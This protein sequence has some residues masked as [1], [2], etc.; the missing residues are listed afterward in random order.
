[1]PAT[2][3]QRPSRSGCRSTIRICPDLRA[4]CWTGETPVAAQIRTISTGGLS[5]ALPSLPEP[6]PYLTVELTRASRG[7]ARRFQ[8]R[9]LY[10][11]LQRDEGCIVGVSFPEKLGTEALNALLA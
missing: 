7:V 6:V 4:I 5:L 9:V 10:A 1:M 2:E 11:F 8:M 3:S